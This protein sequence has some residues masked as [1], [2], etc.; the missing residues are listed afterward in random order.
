ML[1]YYFSEAMIFWKQSI[2]GKQNK[3]ENNND[4]NEKEDRNDKLKVDKKSIRFVYFEC[5]DKSC[6]KINSLWFWH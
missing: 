3:I 1:S 6:Y 2:E 4:C 5:D